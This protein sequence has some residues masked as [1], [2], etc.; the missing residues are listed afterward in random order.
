MGTF[1]DGLS[2]SSSAACFIAG[3]QS[4]AIVP[5]T[6]APKIAPTKNDLKGDIFNPVEVAG[7][8]QVESSSSG[9]DVTSGPRPMLR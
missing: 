2:D 1:L 7:L 5:V 4:T 8:I 3:M 6:A 9:F